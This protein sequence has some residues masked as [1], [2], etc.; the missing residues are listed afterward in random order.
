[1]AEQCI[2]PE[3]LGDLV[4]TICELPLHLEIQELT[5]WPLVQMVEPL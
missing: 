3:D 1:L 5:V 4:V 2:Q